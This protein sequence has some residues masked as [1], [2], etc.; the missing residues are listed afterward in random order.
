MKRHQI[1]QFTLIELLVVIG[2]I[3]IL[4]TV[5]VPK[6]T[7]GLDKASA[8][9]AQT[10]AGTFEKA[11]ITHD[12]DNDG[13][14]K[15]NAKKLAPGN[16]PLTEGLTL[17]KFLS[18]QVKGDGTTPESSSTTEDD[19]Y[20]VTTD[21]SKFFEPR[22]PSD[23]FEFDDSGYLYTEAVDG[24]PPFAK[25]G[26]NNRYQFVYRTSTDNGTVKAYLP[27]D[28]SKT[29]TL[30]G[31]KRGDSKLRVLSFDSSEPLQIIMKEGTYELYKDKEKK[32]L[33]TADE[34]ESGGTF[35]VK[36]K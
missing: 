31:I 18:G 24:E 21:G 13:V 17:Y 32:T 35:Y 2:I 29:L 27:T 20:T 4:A 36:L 19:T 16:S 9:A 23:A 28:T 6:V 30:K 25:N 1:N 33:A 5:V 26:F 14:I 8:V 12:I 11:M 3:G 34:V 7:S 22:L 10:A 15:A